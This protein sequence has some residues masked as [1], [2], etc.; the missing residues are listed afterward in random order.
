MKKFLFCLVFSFS[1]PEKIIA[2]VPLSPQEIVC[3]L[4]LPEKLRKVGLSNLAEAHENL[5]TQMIENGTLGKLFTL[6]ISQEED[7]NSTNYTELKEGGR[8]TGIK[9]NN[10]GKEYKDQQRFRRHWKTKHNPD[11]EGFECRNCHE[12][13][14][15]KTNMERHV[16][17]Q[18]CKR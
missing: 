18:V 10:C 17:N 4:H 14:N 12:I 1:S 3:L 9:C 5:I 11:F 15:R 8:L 13:F 2:S 6:G 16:E 7:R